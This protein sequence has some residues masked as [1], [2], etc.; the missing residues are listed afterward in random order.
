MI[1]LIFG[2]TDFPR[3]ILKKVKSKKVKYLII[4]LTNGKYKKDK[5]S[6]NVSIG[7]LRNI[8]SPNFNDLSLQEFGD[9]NTIIIKECGP[10]KFLYFTCCNICIEK[11]LNLYGRIFQTIKKRELGIK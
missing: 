8:L 10:F 5:H 6:Y 7:E 4:D 3:E 9:K 2:E 11:Y 1:G